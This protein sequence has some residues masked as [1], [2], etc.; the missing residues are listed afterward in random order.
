MKHS[1]Y[2]GVTQAVRCETRP[3]R[4]QCAALGKTHHLGNFETEEEAARAY[5]NVVFHLRDFGIEHPGALNY[6][7]EYTSNPPPM[8]DATRKVVL[9]CSARQGARN[10]KRLNATLS[11]FLPVLRQIPV[12]LRDLEEALAGQPSHVQIPETAEGE[13]GK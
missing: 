2:K 4:A 13:N 6:P 1:C 11:R 8:T 5:D 10:P 12:L 7:A 9:D 3:W